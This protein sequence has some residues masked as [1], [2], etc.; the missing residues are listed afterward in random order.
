MLRVVHSGN[1]GADELERIAQDFEDH[2]LVLDEGTSQF[3][4]WKTQWEHRQQVIDDLLQRLGMQV[5]EQEVFEPAG[6]LNV[7]H[8]SDNS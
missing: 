4:S 8:H 1:G 5:G 7:V 2:N 3:E 6:R